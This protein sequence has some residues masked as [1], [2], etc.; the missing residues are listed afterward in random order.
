MAKDCLTC[1]SKSC[2]TFGADCFGVHD[3]SLEIYAKE[4][5]IHMLKHASQ[6][7]DGG[8]AGELSRFQ[9]VVEFCKKQEYKAVG[10]AYCFGLEPLAQEISNILVDTGVPVVPARCSMGGIKENQID[11]DKTNDVYSCNPA[12]QATFLNQRA[13]FVIELGL[14]LGHDVLFHQ[15]LEVPFTVLLVKDRVYSH[16]P[17]EGINNYKKDM[18][19]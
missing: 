4:D 14:C 8:R 19:K 17:L 3:K 1:S 13:D 2:R 16:A 15:E 11:P 7:V 5:N 6:L 12:G 18:E 10:L 9:E